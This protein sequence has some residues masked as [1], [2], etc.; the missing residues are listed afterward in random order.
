LVLAACQGS[1]TG[2]PAVPNAPPPQI[3]I[4]GSPYFVPSFRSTYHPTLI[5]KA[6]RAVKT[7]NGYRFSATNDNRALQLL[8]GQS[9]GTFGSR[10]DAPPDF[11]ILAS[12]IHD[13]AITACKERGLELTVIKLAD[14]VG[15]SSDRNLRGA[16]LTY[17]SARVR[18][19]G[20]PLLNYIQQNSAGLMTSLPYG[21]DFAPGK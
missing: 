8:C 11:A 9:I 10:P 13:D 18:D 21:E 6:T 14:F 17:I 4:V 12:P 7:E 5:E 1:G 3:V 19:A 16:W 15:R 2:N 20:W